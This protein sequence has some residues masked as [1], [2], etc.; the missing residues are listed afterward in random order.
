MFSLQRDS[1]STTPKHL[2]EVTSATPGKLDSVPPGTLDV[3]PP[4]VVSSS[5]VSA[6]RTKTRAEADPCPWWSSDA[7]QPNRAAVA[8]RN[9]NSLGV[10]WRLGS[11]G[12]EGRV[13]VRVNWQ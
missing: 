1:L 10:G 9:P 8:T 6:I 12:G 3:A 7:N 2:G 13:V 4:G 11:G 5:A